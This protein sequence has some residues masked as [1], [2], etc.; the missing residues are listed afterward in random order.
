MDSLAKVHSR[1]QPPSLSLNHHRP[2]FPKLANSLSFRNSPSSPSPF[3]IYSIRASSSSVP[4][5]NHNKPS[6]V[7]TLNPLS[8]PL[9]K[10][11]CVTVAAASL[12]FM[13]LHHTARPA[14]AAPVA[15]PAPT[16]ESTD[17]SSS[18]GLSFEEKEKE[19]QQ[20]LAENPGDVDA[21][22]SLMEVRL[23]SH[24]LLEAI[25]VID[26]LIE[27]EP[28]EFEW[29]LLKAQVHSYTGDYE[30]ATKGFE[31]I[32]QRDPVRVEAFHGLVMAYSESGYKLKDLEKRIENAMEKCKKEKRK[33]DFRD[34]KLLI[35]QIRVMENRHFEALKVYE[36]L[37]KEEPRDFRPYLCQGIIYTLLKKTDEAEKQFEKFRKL[38]PKNHPYRE[39]FVDNMVATKL[40]GEKVERDGV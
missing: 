20:H 4:E 15:P 39:Y 33:S 24:K 26:R 28:N 5:R 18:D 8:S 35:A 34:F 23:K 10:A 13:R 6:L 30:L 29:P 16:V 19:I 38:V 14:I 21:L 31:E 3:K 11:A 12:F 32:L 2:S 9:V 22:R 37:V 17:S 1:Y 40:F 25:E 36:E 27:I 7:Q